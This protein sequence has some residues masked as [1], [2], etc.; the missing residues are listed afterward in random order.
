MLKG[1]LLVLSLTSAGQGRLMDYYNGNIKTSPTEARTIV[2]EALADHKDGYH[3]EIALLMSGYL[4]K[5]AG[6]PV[7]AFVDYDACYRG[8]S[9]LDTT[10]YYLEVSVR[11]NI[12]A[13]LDNFKEYDQAL[14]IY[15][16]AVAFAKKYD[17]KELAS[18]YA[19][20]GNS[21]RDLRDAEN[22]L[23]YYTMSIKLSESV[24]DYYKTA[25]INNRL[26]LSFYSAKSYGEAEYYF[27][28]SIAF[29]SKLSGSKLRV[30]G[31]AYHNLAHVFG[32]QGET[33]KAIDHL[34]QAL[35]FKNGQDLFVTLLDL[36]EIYLKIGEPQKAKDY[37]TQ[38]LEYYPGMA[39]SKSEDHAVYKWL[40]LA[41]KELGNFKQAYEYNAKYISAIELH[42]TNSDLLNE[43]IVATFAAT[44]IDSHKKGRE[45][46]IAK[47][48]LKWVLI[49][50][51]V[52]LLPLLILAV[53]NMRNRKK[54]NA[55]LDGIESFIESS[56]GS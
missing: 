52:A 35:T 18:L 49:V 2:D 39:S 11:K 41:E 34:E 42:N 29:K 56:L 46:E 10:D 54:L 44:L 30:I 37:L 48:R 45:F 4:H 14:K 15:K 55:G 6:D 19:N 50:L 9:S 27:L 17:R 20:M 40:D 7:K 24:D 23:K 43:K 47:R 1:L 32:D 38:S 3:R 36:G 31:Q 26:G 53:L 12:G 21:Y 13:L 51:F 33:R 5:K 25:Q 8:L 16:E 22:L 28:K